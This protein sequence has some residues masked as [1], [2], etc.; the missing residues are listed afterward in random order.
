MTLVHTLVEPALWLRDQS[1]RLLFIWTVPGSR[2]LWTAKRT[3]RT[4]P[5]VLAWWSGD[6]NALIETR[7]RGVFADAS[8]LDALADV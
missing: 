3:A 7:R 1:N 8:E 4:D 6:V 5:D 2:E